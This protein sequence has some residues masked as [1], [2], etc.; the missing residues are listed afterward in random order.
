MK[1]NKNGRTTVT[2]QA[3]GSRVWIGAVAC[4]L[5]CPFFIFVFSR[6]QWGLS[7]GRLLWTIC[8][9][10]VGVDQQQPLCVP[11]VCGV[12]IQNTAASESPPLRCP[13]AAKNAFCL[14]N[15]IICQW[16]G[17]AG[18]EKITQLNSLA[19][20]KKRWSVVT[21][22]TFVLS[23]QFITLGGHANRSRVPAYLF[24]EFFF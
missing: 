9:G 20:N 22:A 17:A 8:V 3:K 24:W 18:V 1:K 11:V 5:C 14:W 19:P 4:F 21:A 6:L 15:K 2:G 13:T 16:A 23:A 7:V 12:Q 10:A